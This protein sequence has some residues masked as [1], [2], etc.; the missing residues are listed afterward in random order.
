V[1]NEQT[2]RR[3]IGDWR[4]AHSKI[5]KSDV[6]QAHQQ[7]AIANKLIHS[8]RRSDFLLFDPFEYCGVRPLERFTRDFL[9]ALFNHHGLD[10][11]G[12]AAFGA[13][14]DEAALSRNGRYK[15]QVARVRSEWKAARLQ[16]QTEVMMGYVRPDIVL[17]TDRIVVAIEIKRRNGVETQH[18]GGVSQ[19]GR[20]RTGSLDYARQRSIPDANVLSLFLTPDAQDP[21]DSSVIPI[22]LVRLCSL[23]DRQI[24]SSKRLGP[25]TRQS[26]TSFIYFLTRG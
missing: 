21:A 24:A 11:L 9:A 17:S 12:R 22:D 20:L 4:A 23:L 3:L 14:L 10:Y 26:M 25:E 5:K 1:T 13:L 2:L 15:R 18:P 16:C 6:E 19:T 7:V 8:Y